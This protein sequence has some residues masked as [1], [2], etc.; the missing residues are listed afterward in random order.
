MTDPTRSVDPVAQPAVTFGISPADVA[1]TEAIEQEAARPG[2]YEVALKSLNQWQLAWRRFRRHKLA[3]VGLAIFSVM[4]FV[5]IFGSIIWP[6][7]R[8]DIQ[9]CPTQKC[10]PP[11]LEYPFGTDNGGRRPLPTRGKSGGASVGGRRATHGFGGS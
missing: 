11:S 10:F 3:M 1:S 8:L 7:D 9:R 6:F 2:D 5:A 4:L